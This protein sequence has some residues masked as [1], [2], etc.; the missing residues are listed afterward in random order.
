M[1][2][3]N[4]GIFDS[5]HA[6]IGKTEMMA[7]FMDQDMPHQMAQVFP[8]FD[9]VVQQRPAVEKDHADVVRHHAYT[10]LLQIDA[11]V[12]AQKSVRRA[13]GHLAHGLIIGKI[14]YLDDHVD[15]LPAQELGIR[16]RASRARSSI[17]AK[18]GAKRSPLSMALSLTRQ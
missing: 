13:H 4:A 8:A 9:P 12:H 11:V 6:S 18:V 3:L 7:D 14:H 16:A 17:S 1:G 5:R 15:Q 2:E 10:F